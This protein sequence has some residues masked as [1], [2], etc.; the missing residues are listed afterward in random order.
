LGSACNS[1]DAKLSHVLKAMGLTDAQI[2]SS[3]RLSLGR[4]NS[5]DEIK[6]IVKEFLGHIN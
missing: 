1:A 4:F 6:T 2:Q 3:F 5:S